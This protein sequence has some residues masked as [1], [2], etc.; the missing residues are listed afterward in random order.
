LVADSNYWSGFC[1]AAA[2]AVPHLD[3]ASP[4]G[5]VSQRI[6]LRPGRVPRVCIQRGGLGVY[7]IGP[8][9]Y[10]Y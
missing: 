7:A 1:P 4:M 6:A 10:F 3:V 8:P 9:P 5:G 2:V